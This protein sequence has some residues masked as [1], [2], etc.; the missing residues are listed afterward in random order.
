M[1]SHKFTMLWIKH[2]NDCMIASL[3]FRQHT[4]NS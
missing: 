2:N 1:I 3:E 4:T